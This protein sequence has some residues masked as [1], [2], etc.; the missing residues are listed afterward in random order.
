MYGIG[1]MID[2]SKAKLSK[3]KGAALL[4]KFAYAKDKKGARTPVN[5]SPFED[6]TYI[7][8]LALVKRGGNAFE[9]IPRTSAVD[10]TLRM[11]P[12]TGGR[13]PRCPREPMV[14][15]KGGGVDPSNVTLVSDTSSPLGS[16]VKTRV[17]QGG[18]APRQD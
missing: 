11:E 10:E 1:L 8:E 14:T 4:L 13:G 5:V 16:P 15:Q 3:G 2:E 17:K 6:R 9:P 7:V 18:K 12:S